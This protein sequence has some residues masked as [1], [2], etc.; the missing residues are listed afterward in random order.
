MD[1]K[2]YVVS[3][4]INEFSLYTADQPELLYAEGIQGA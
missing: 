4:C 3:Y 2:A 1:S